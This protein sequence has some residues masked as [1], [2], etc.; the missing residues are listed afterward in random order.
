MGLLLVMTTILGLIIGIRKT[1]GPYFGHRTVKLGLMQD[2]LHGPCTSYDG[3]P[4]PYIV[5]YENLLGPYIA[6]REA[7]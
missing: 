1:L 3:H 2:S 6:H 4:Q 5:D 7:S